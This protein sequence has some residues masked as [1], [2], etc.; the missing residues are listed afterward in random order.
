MGSTTGSASEQTA[1]E[2]LYES[3]STTSSTREQTAVKVLHE[4]GSTTSSTSEQTAVEV[5]YTALRWEAG[6]LEDASLTLHLSTIGHIQSVRNDYPYDHS[7]T[8]S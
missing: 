5:L 8:A 1:V 4:S 6:R 3:G 7:S 2:M